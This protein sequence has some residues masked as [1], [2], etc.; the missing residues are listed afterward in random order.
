MNCTG[1]ANPRETN[2]LK[3][4]LTEIGKLKSAIADTSSNAL[5]TIKD[6]LHPLGDVISMITSAIEDDPPLAL[7][8]GGIIRKGFSKELDE[9]RSLAFSGK[10]WI[11]DLQKKERDRTGI[12]SLKVGFNNVFGYYIEITYTHK[13]KIPS[14]YI[15]KQTLTNAERYVTP[16]LKEQEEKILHAEEKM[17]ELE[18]QLFNELRMN[19]AEHAEAIQTNARLVAL[20]DCLTSLASAAVEYNYVCPEVNDSTALEVFDGR[21]PVIERLLPPGESYTP[22][23]VRVV[24]FRTDEY[25]E[26]QPH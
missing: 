12:P 22:N 19:V 5:T 18:T 21:H 17:L 1:R 20:L 2:T 11:A 14:N 15:R 6:G 23:S 16:E 7:S 3:F 26:V 25:A 9:L 24:H 10:T 13:N 4:N 8:D